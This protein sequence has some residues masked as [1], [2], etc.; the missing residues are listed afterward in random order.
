[1]N[2]N[3]ISL[4]A[5][6]TTSGSYT[7][8]ENN[9]ATGTNSVPLNRWTHYA[10]CRSGNTWKIF[11]NGNE[12]Y[13]A[14]L[15]GTIADSTQPFGI[16]DYS[17]TP[18]TYEFQGVISNFRVVKGTA[19]Y[20]SNFTAPTEPLTNVTNTT[21][22]CCNSSSSATAAT[23]TPGTITANGNVISATNEMSAYLVL[24][25]PGISTS[26]SANLVT[27]GTFDSNTTNWSSLSSATLS[28]VDGKLRVTNSTT[29]YGKAEQEITTEA[30][31]RYTFSLDSYT[32][33]TSDEAQIRVGST[34][35]GFDLLAATDVPTGH[36]SV[37]FTATGTSSYINVNNGG[38]VASEY[39][40]FDNIVVKQEDAPRDYSADIKGSGSNKT[41][42]PN[43]G[44]GVG[45]EI[46]SYYGSAMNFDGDGDSLQGPLNSSDLEMG[47][48]DFT[49]EAWVNPS[50]VSGPGGIA[51]IW[52]GSSNDRSWLLYHGSGGGLNFIISAD[53]S[54]NDVVA[55]GINMTTGQWYHVVGEKEGTTIRIIVN[56]VVA[57]IDT[58]AAASV[59]NAA[60]EFRIGV[61]DFSDGT[62]QEFTGHIQDVRVYKGVAKYKGGFDVPKPYTPVGIE[63]WRTV[64]DCTANNFCTWNP[65]YPGFSNNPSFTNG[66]VSVAETGSVTSQ[67]TGTM[68][69]STGKWY[70]EARAENVT[71]ASH[72]IG[73]RAAEWNTANSQNSLAY[74][75]NG[76]VYNYSSSATSQSTY[77]TGDIIGIAF[78]PVNGR[79]WFSK[80]GVWTNG[81]PS[82]GS[83]QNVNYTPSATTPFFCFD[84]VAGT[85]IWDTNFGQNPSFSGLVTPGT[86][87]DS[88]G[89]GLFKY[90]PPSGFLALCE[91]NLPTPA[92]AN[93]GDYFKTVLYTGDGNEGR[94][95]TGVGFKPDFVWIKE[96]TSLA[97]V[98][99]HR[100]FDSI[101]GP[102]NVLL[103]D[104]DSIELSRPS[105]VRSFDK[106]GFS[107]G[108]SSA[109]NED[110][111]T[112]VAWCWK[113]G[114]P[115]AANND[116][117]IASQVSANQTAGFSIATFT[118]TLSGSGTETF[119]HGLGKAPS[120]VIVKGRDITSSWGVYHKGIGPTG[121][122]YLDL[123]NQTSTASFHWGDTAP[124][125]SVVT[126]GY[127]SATGSAADRVAY[128]WAEIEGF[129]KFGSYVGNGDADGPFVYCGFK[130]AWV[131][132]K[133]TD[134]SGEN[135]LIYD[136][137]RNS[138]NPTSSKLAP[139]SEV[140]ENDAS[141]GTNTQN[142]LDLLS[143]GFKLRTT[144]TGTNASGGTYI[145][146]AFAESPFK[147]ANAK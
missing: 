84:N 106:D 145:F 52:D 11:I 85:Q 38:N 137:S 77:T 26:T 91:D 4:Y 55:S 21:L 66:N 75:S 127:G 123:D 125:D 34:S 92:I 89:K 44:A 82:T 100:L 96:R 37:S 76:E 40:E 147:T 146:A 7:I 69:P 8:V 86:N 17:E 6:S 24:A 110:G 98:S 80:N 78:D 126:L 45:Y 63:S 130:P 138:E 142:T 93:P 120:M 39:S 35:N 121:L 68:G 74:R 62:P 111:S 109:P 57:A 22:L 114:G 59:Y 133:R 104:N 122:V 2:T 36:H 16:G 131:M 129:S 81:N 87:T 30:G 15:S 132:I 51:G 97:I 10:L 19:L 99:S 67:G 144:N 64:A 23:V 95:I 113:A 33:T 79:L 42:T 140:M 27:N 13:S 101:R 28:V 32:G 47:S 12:L 143:N 14:T 49:V 116:G 1:M 141:I 83:G 105:E 50:D 71:T 107:L 135:W 58:A 94:S 90:A 102:G 70:Y 54:T 3:S 134:T 136:C 118:T 41:L 53:G 29:D 112:I 124:T 18:G 128:C 20:T 60:E 31:K 72:L 43:G 25:V 139:N 9:N 46:P 103:S 117:T 61:Y 108:S 88:N 56:G 119:G 115:A 73:I 65:L 48:D 5:S